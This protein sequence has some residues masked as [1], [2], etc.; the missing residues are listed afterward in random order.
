M[1]E[2]MTAA[3]LVICQGGYNTVSEV[4]QLGLPSICVPGM[5]DLDDQV[6]A[7]S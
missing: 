6:R 4:S 5:R 1:R 7:R 2:L 3:D